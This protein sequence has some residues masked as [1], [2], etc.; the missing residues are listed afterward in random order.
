MKRSKGR[1]ERREGGRGAETNGGGIRVIVLSKAN[2]AL[3]LHG[4]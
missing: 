1:E 2:Q 3:N 4:G